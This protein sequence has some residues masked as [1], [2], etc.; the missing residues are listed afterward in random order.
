MDPPPYL[1]TSSWTRQDEEKKACPSEWGQFVPSPWG[2]GKKKLC[3]VTRAQYREDL[4]SPVYPC[5]ASS[6]YNPGGFNGPQ[7]GTCRSDPFNGTN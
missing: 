7:Y 3:L 6:S 4:K 1:K 5:S 2:P